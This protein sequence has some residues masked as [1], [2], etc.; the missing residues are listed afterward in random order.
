MI[1]Y[2]KFNMLLVNYSDEDSVPCD[3]YSCLTYSKENYSV[4]YLFSILYNFTLDY[5]FLNE[6]ITHEEVSPVLGAC[7]SRGI[8][9]AEKGAG[10]RCLCRKFLL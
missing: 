3:V 9:D 7:L 2:E 10:A 6:T 1:V 5:L 8:H 4:H